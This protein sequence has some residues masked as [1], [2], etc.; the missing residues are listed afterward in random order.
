MNPYYP[1][2]QESLLQPPIVSSKT[3]M[4]NVFVWMFLA[5]GISAVTAYLASHNLEIFQ[6]FHGMDGRQNL[7]G[8]I[9]MFLPL[10]FVLLMSFGFQRLPLA[11]LGILFTVYAVVNGV[12]FS[13]I[14]MLYSSS[15]ILS[16]FVGAAGMFGVMAI[17]GYTTNK[18]LTKFGSIMF[19]G[20][21]GLIIMSVVNFFM[22]SSVMNYIVGAIGVLVFTG[23]TAYDIQMLKNIG[24]GIDQNGESMALVDRKKYAII[25]ALNLYLDFINI[26]LSLLRLFGSRD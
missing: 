5:L 22:Q 3:F 15:S 20:L 1:S 14:F 9:F 2:E 13:Y 4:S 6:M 17:A 10:A 7:L 11:V 23:L 26:F 19:M 24:Q 12:C 25:G 16:C 8:K 21:I 18:D